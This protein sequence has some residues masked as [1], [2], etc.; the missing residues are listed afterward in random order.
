MDLRGAQCH[1]DSIV[2]GHT[3]MRIGLLCVLS[4]QYLYAYL[5]IALLPRETSR[6]SSGSA[7][8][9]DRETAREPRAYACAFVGLGANE[10]AWTG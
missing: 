4:Y 6:D 1:L 3:G 9:E 2:A 8:E 7:R 5:C 10:T